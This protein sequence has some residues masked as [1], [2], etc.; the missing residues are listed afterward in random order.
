MGSYYN[1][2]LQANKKHEEIYGDKVTEGEYFRLSTYD[3]DNGAKLMESSFIDNNYQNA[4]LRLIE[5]NPSY[6][7]FTCDYTENSPYSWD[8]VQEISTDESEQDNKFKG[9]RGFIINHTKKEYISIKTYVKLFAEHSTEWAVNPLPILANIEKQ[10]MGG[11][12]YR[13]DDDRRGTWAND[14]ISYS[15]KL[16][17]FKAFKNVT[18]DNIFWEE[19]QTLIKVDEDKLNATKEL[20]E[21][22]IKDN[23]I[24]M[25]SRDGETTL[26]NEELIALLRAVRQI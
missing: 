12:D 16:G 18:K 9:D 13:N 19:K 14:L 21:T 8:E 20:A 11:G 23:G 2:A 24:D 17:E 7:C 3:F 1:A 25:W 10:S 15:T 22:I 5:D 6:L 4:V 26:S